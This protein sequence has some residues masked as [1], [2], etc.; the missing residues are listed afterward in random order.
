MTS[1]SFTTRTPASLRL[2][3]TASLVWQTCDGKKSVSDIAAALQA[4][5]ARPVDEDLVRIALGQLEAANLWTLSAIHPVAQP[6]AGALSCARQAPFRC[7]CGRRNA[8][9]PFSGR[10]AVARRE[11]C[12]QFRGGRAEL[13]PPRRLRPCPPRARRRSP[14][15]ASCA[16]SPFS[17]A[18]QAS[19]RP[20]RASWAGQPEIPHTSRSPLDKPD[21]RKWYRWSL[22]RPGS[23]TTTLLPNL[24]AQHQPNPSR[25]AVSRRGAAASNGDLLSRRTA[26]TG[27]ARVKGGTR[28]K[29]AVRGSCRHRGRSRGR[30]PPRGRK[31]PGLLLEKPLALQASRRRVRADLRRAD[32]LGTPRSGLTSGCRRRRLVGA[33]DI[34]HSTIDVGIAASALIIAADDTLYEAK[35]AGGNR[36]A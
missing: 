7:S 9:T 23:C 15:A 35:P 10:F 28:K 16:W 13:F 25:W 21:T 32:G 18:W 4:R 34:S 14:E 1:S 29:Q 33:V 26:E 27:R 3:P 31:A 30:V 20:P 5:V 36:V 11:G 17:S 12:E 2:N 22:T 6:S 24:L 8:A 19:F